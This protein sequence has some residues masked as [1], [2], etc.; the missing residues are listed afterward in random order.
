MVVDLGVDGTE[1]LQGFDFSEPDHCPL[2]SSERQVGIF[3][4]IVLPAAH[5]AS[6]GA[7]D[8]LHRGAVGT[9][10][11]GDDHRS[12]ERRVGKECVSQCRSRWSPYHSKNKK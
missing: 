7:T 12:E 3:R 11:V 8:F 5:L 4:A 2:S 9:Q 6:I 10:A 1:L